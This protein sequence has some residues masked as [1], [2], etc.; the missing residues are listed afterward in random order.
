MNKSNYKLD[1]LKGNT[2]NISIQQ[3]TRNH[4]KQTSGNT[5]TTHTHRLIFVRYPV[6]KLG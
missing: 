1:L 3:K 4:A 5:F 6:Q 2:L